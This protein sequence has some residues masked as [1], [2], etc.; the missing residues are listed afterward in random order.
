MMS[1]AVVSAGQRKAGDLAFHEQ[2]GF[3]QLGGVVHDESVGHED[4]P[5]GKPVERIEGN[6]ATPNPTTVTIAPAIQRSSA[7]SSG[8]AVSPTITMRTDGMS[9]TKSTGPGARSANRRSSP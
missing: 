6:Q 1:L 2:D 8:P 7:S 5:V 9:A 4:E 3:T